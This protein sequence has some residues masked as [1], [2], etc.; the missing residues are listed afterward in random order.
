MKNIV[1]IG[2][3]GSGKT[4]MGRFLSQE[5]EYDF[6]DTDREMEAATGVKVNLIVKKYGKIRYDSEENLVVKRL[7]RKERAIIATGGTFIEK[8]ENVE[9]LKRNSVFVYLQVDEDVIVERLSRRSV[10]PFQTKGS[11]K[12]LVPRIYDQCRP[13]YEQYGDIIVN[14]TN[15]SMEETAEVILKELKE[16]YDFSLDTETN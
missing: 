5:L 6:Y 3:M 4:A 11:L 7:A 14:T 12:E 15:L 8:Q 16:N 13:L 10:K 2:F 9:T 1:L